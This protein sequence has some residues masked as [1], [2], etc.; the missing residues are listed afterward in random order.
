METEEQR[1]DLHKLTKSELISLIEEQRENQKKTHLS[2]EC[3]E[4]L[5]LNLL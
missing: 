1:R 4:I 5:R 2:R 3:T